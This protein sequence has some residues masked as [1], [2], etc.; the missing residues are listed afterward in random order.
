MLQVT[1]GDQAAA[2]VAAA[3]GEVTGGVCGH[4]DLTGPASPGWLSREK[5][6][7]CRPGVRGL[8]RALRLY[9]V[10]NRVLPGPGG[11]G[12]DSAQS[13]LVQGARRGCPWF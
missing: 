9:V 5:C 12:P 2:V 1:D 10:L 6:V 4:A 8:R 3:D 7:S 11:P 13:S